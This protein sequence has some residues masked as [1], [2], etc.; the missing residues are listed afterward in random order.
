MYSY[1]Q[2]FLKA[3]TGARGTTCHMSAPPGRAP[4]LKQTQTTLMPAAPCP[5]CLTTETLCRVEI[6]CRTTKALTLILWCSA[7]VAACS[8]TTQTAGRRGSCANKHPGTRKSSRPP[9]QGTHCPQVKHAKAGLSEVTGGAVEPLL[10]SVSRQCSCHVSVPCWLV[11]SPVW[12][13]LALPLLSHQL[14]HRVVS[15]ELRKENEQCGAKNHKCG[16]H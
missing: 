15:S 11:R 10:V 2:E 1:A 14:V 9:V 3:T 6:P 8:Q 13:F 16:G 7:A 5:R 12:F 4:K